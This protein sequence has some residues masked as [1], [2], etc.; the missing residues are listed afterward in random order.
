VLPFLVLGACQT[1]QGGNAGWQQAQ[2]VQIQAAGRQL[3]VPVRTTR[4]VHFAQD[5]ATFVT[6][7]AANLETIPATELPRGID[8]GVAYLDAPRQALPTGYYRLR[9][10]GDPRGVGVTQ[11]RVQWIGTDGRVALEIPATLDVESMTLPPRAAEEITTVTL[12]TIAAKE[13]GGCLYK[14]RVCYLCT[15]GET[16]CIWKCVWATAPSLHGDETQ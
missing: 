16:T 9:A 4:M 5:G 7:P 6:A 15:N 3:G 1:L 10:F 13:S 12:T 8:I 2:A 14:I 11:G